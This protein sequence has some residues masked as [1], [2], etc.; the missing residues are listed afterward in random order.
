[1]RN[2]ESHELI[3]MVSQ[4]IARA[5]GSQRGEEYFPS[6]DPDLRDDKIVACKRRVQTLRT[7]REQL[8]DELSK[9]L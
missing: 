4:Q 2:E 7:I 6:S 9:P 3:N 1:M 5:L 8:E